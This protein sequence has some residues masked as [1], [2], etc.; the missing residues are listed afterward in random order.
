MVV[1]DV[2]GIGE[3]KVKSRVWRTQP[4]EIP[5]HNVEAVALPQSAGSVHKERVQLNTRSLR[6]IPRLADTQEGRVERPCANGRVKE[7]HPLVAHQSMDV[8]GKTYGKR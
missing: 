1:P 3:H 2:R 8:A 6:N 5:M 7:A 4:C